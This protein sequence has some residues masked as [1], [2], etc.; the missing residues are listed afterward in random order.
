MHLTAT[1]LRSTFSAAR[2]ATPLKTT[3]PLAASWAPQTRRSCTRQQNQRA[4]ASAGGA[5]QP[6]A[7]AAG[8]GAAGGA[9]GKVAVR[10]ALDEMAKDGA[11]ARK[12]SQF[13]QW[14][15]KGGR[16]EPEGEPLPQPQL[17]AGAAA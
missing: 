13:R 5:A 10:T 12:E 14:I 8:T 6:V 4:M 17:P 2:L 15:R 9:D 3:T 11:F 7:A 1:A 16:F